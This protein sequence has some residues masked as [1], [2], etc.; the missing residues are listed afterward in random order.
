MKKFI[1]L[2]MLVAVVAITVGI[3]RRHAPA[4]GVVVAASAPTTTTTVLSAP[5]TAPTTAKPAVKVTQTTARAVVATTSTTARPAVAPTTTTTVAPTT[6]TTIAVGSAPTCTVS[7]DKASVAYGEPQVLR[8]T[9]SLTNTSMAMSV[10]YPADPNTMNKVPRQFVHQATTD[11]S[12]SDSWTTSSP[13]RSVGPVH[14][15]VNFYPTGAKQIGALC[16]MTFQAT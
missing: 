6:T 7:P 16:S 1:V 12:G 9:S 3:V 10:T 2:S 15:S 14:V 4:L 5:A 8:L 13:P 11:S